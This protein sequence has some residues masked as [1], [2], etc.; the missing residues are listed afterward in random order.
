MGG[1][2][3][4]LPISELDKQKLRQLATDTPVALLSLIQAAPGE[5]DT[6]MG[7]SAAPVRQQVENLVP[8]SRRSLTGP[9]PEFPLG[10]Q[11]APR[12]LVPQP[13]FDI[14]IRDRLFEEWQG[15]L[16]SSATRDSQRAK[17]LEAQL[18]SLLDR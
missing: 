18:N 7:D 15:L 5:F 11:M 10:A 4:A 6:F 8:F 17:D 2:I 12:P 1:F 13:A 9:A 16:K 14:G 3:D